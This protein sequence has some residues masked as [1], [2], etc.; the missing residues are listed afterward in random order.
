MGRRNRPP[1]FD[2][3][4]LATLPSNA[5][6]RVTAGNWR[7]SKDRVLSH[8]IGDVKYGVRILARSRVFTAIAV[9]ALAL[10]IGA[11]TAVFSAIDAVLL[12]P[13]PYRD[14]A[15]LALVWEDASHAGFPKN[16]PAP[17]NYVDW[18]KQN[19]VF[20][21]MAALQGLAAN[22]TGDGPP[23]LV[24][25]NRVTPEFFDVLGV[26][27]AL[28]RTLDAK[29]DLSGEN[30]MVIGHGLWQR[31]FGGDRGIVGRTVRVNDEPYT[32]VGVMPRGF[33]F[34]TP[35]TEVWTPARF[36]PEV[37]A[38]R[39]SHFLTVVARLKP[40]V[41]WERAKSDMRAIAQR[42]QTDYPG[43]NERVGVVVE[44]LAEA[45]VENSRTGLLVLMAGAGFVLLIACANVAN[46]LL[47]K[48]AA[49]RR[50][51]AVRAALGAGRGRLL[52]QLITESVL[53]AA[54][55]GLTGIALAHWGVKLLDRLAQD[56]L[57]APLGLNAQVLL[58]SLAVSIVTGLLFGM[59]PALQAS[60]LD[61]NDALKQG[62]RANAGGRRTTSRD[63]LVIAEVAMALVLV[64]GA[65]LMLR[66]L[67]QL[68][69]V[70]V[71]FRP[72][73]LLTMRTNLPFP[74][75]RDPQLRQRRRD[76]VLE[77]V[78][79]LPGVR[80]AAFTSNLPFTALGNTNS[81]QIEGQPRRP[82]E[83]YDALYRIVTTDYLKLLGVRLLE[84]R[85]FGPEDRA[86]TTR[87]VVINDTLARHFFPGEHAVGKRMRIDGPELYTI[88]GVIADVRERGINPSPKNATYLLSPQT[89]Q[90]WNDPQQL[91][92]RA[93][94][95]PLA[96]AGAVRAAVWHSDKDLPVLEVRPM[97]DIVENDFASR[98]QQM[99]LL[100]AFAALALTLAALGIYGVLSY[101]VVQQTREIG[102]RMAL[103][104]RAG[105]IV[106]QVAAKGALLTGTGLAAGAVIALATT[107]AMRSML[108]GVAPSDPAT[109]A[110]VIAILAAIGVAACAAPAFRAARVDPMIALRDE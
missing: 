31:R 101:L 108:Y 73:G 64:A 77:E 22:L 61:L 27:A 66:T 91:V 62:G 90:A 107:R 20:T 16:T 8:L 70:D 83:S 6:F 69:G 25:G 59:L 34:P 100:L 93:D 28:G 45:A 13:L 103:G 55:G 79:S 104:A 30:V 44:P 99:R 102:V 98:R 38:R 51:L 5:D 88:I 43:T 85:L 94:G 65:G 89:P 86:G 32:V 105:D 74:K 9:L 60:R 49:R 76:A 7:R 71:G 10:G 1:T 18:K 50:E 4:Q 39:G 37:L 80:L 26:P 52:G 110:A 95:D 21:D 63:L 67:A 57:D 42:L 53:L 12:R 109:F 14:P 75:Y 40:G 106:R 24:R 54:A 17:A 78:R 92:V 84:G 3:P 47:A 72:E 97:T 23:E 29:D 82:D 19:Q 15:R 81:F 46:L 35:R 36:T 68:R 87:V 56:R 48:A 11:N 33:R 96:L 58:F 41:T 2:S